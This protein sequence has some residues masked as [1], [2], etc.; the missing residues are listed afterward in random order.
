M[1]FV[2]F[3]LASAT[4]YVRTI[5]QGKLEGR[6]RP[7]GM[8][9]SQSVGS[10]VEEAGRLGNSR[11]QHFEG[12]LCYDALFVWV[13]LIRQFKTFCMDGRKN[14]HEKYTLGTRGGTFWEH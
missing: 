7:R 12:R 10:G 14:E 2:C 9:E 3:M 11:N 8:E 6:L 1:I 4:H 5:C 13:L